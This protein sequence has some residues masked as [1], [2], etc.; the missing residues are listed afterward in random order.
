[1][2]FPW[3]KMADCVRRTISQNTYEIFFQDAAQ[4]LINDLVDLRNDL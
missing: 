3:L 4:G 1:M 2:I